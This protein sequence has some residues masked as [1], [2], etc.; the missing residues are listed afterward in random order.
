MHAFWL[1]API[2]TH[3]LYSKLPSSRYYLYLFCCQKSASCVRRK[4][5][6]EISVRKSCPKFDP[7]YSIFSQLLYILGHTIR[8]QVNKLNVRSNKIIFQCMMSWCL[9]E[10][11]K[12]LFNS[13]FISTISNCVMYLSLNSWNLI[14]NNTLLSLEPMFSKQWILESCFRNMLEGQETKVCNFK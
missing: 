5:E 6:I 9:K 11:K 2:P 14:L 4:R 8:Q 3:G 7:H 1:P 12:T 13:E 10:K